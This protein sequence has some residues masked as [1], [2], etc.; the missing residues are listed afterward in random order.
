MDQSVTYRFGLEDYAALVRA[1]RTL[2]P[3]GPLGRWGRIALFT[4]VFGT[5]VLI[6]AVLT[7]F[8]DASMSTLLGLAAFI[9]GLLFVSTAVGDLVGDPLLFRYRYRRLASAGKDM[10][11]QFSDDR[12]LVRCVGVE[13]TIPWPSFK[14]VIETKDHLFLFLSRAEGLVVPMRAV[15]SPQALGALASAIRNRVGGAPQS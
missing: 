10:T 1:A 6:A 5:L 12:L 8:R 3:L 11:L 2:G 7:T 15:G 14:W 4:V 9:Y 13:S